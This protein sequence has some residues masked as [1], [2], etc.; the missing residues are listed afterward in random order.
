MLSQLPFPTMKL[1]ALIAAAAILVALG[2]N[3]TTAWTAQ[4]TQ[5]KQLREKV[6]RLQQ[7]VRVLSGQRNQ[8][9]RERNDAQAAITQGL[10]PQVGIV[11]AAGSI[12]QLW[13]LIFEPIRVAW[14]CGATLFQGQTFWSLDVELSDYDAETDATRRCEA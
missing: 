11:A 14:P 3:T 9:R 2:A 5:A 8:A 13:H 7:R 1:I 12:S 10:A 4:D 6:K